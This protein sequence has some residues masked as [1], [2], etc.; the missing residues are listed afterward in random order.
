MEEKRIRP[1]SFFGQDNVCAYY[2]QLI[3][4]EKDYNFYIHIFSIRKT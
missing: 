1:L 3:C 2:V 4:R